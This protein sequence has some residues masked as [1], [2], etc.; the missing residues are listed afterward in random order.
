MLIGNCFWLI[1][2]Q[3]G[4]WSDVGTIWIFQNNLSDFR[5]NQACH[6]IRINSKIKTLIAE[7]VA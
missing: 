2:E 5:N 3:V 1:G 6:G 7:I 4:V